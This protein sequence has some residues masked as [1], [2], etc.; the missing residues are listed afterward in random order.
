MVLYHIE[1]RYLSSAFGTAHP[2]Y[3]HE[4]HRKGA[5]HF[6]MEVNDKFYPYLLYVIMMQQMIACI[7]FQPFGPLTNL[8]LGKSDE[9]MN[10]TSI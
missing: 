9:P 7:V 1:G 8:V 4:G 2:R 3:R 5:S 10:R 6:T